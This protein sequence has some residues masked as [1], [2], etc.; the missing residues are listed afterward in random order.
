M[1]KIRAV[2][3]IFLG[4]IISTCSL[5]GVSNN[6]NNIL[7]SFDQNAYAHD[8][9]PYESASFLSFIEQLRVESELVQSNLADN[10]ISL[11][12]Q[13]ANKAAALLTPNITKEIAERVQRVSQDLSTAVSDLQNI[14]SQQQQEPSASEI[15]QL[16][17]LDAILDEAVSA[18]IDREQ[19]DNV[20][21]Q[22]LAFANLVNSV[23]RDYGNAYA[24]G[25]DMTNMSNMAGMADM[26]G[27]NRNMSL[28]SVMSTELDRNY[29]LVNAADYQSAQAL[30]NKAL[31]I[32]KT[33][34]APMES[35]SNR[36]AFIMNG[37]MQL[38]NS[39]KSKA[40]PMDIMMIVHTQIH[41]NLMKMFG[42]QLQK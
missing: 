40:S 17:N 29:S 16:A 13:H 19:R 8:F 12:H 9:T 37:L 26:P 25:F 24:V 7:P 5:N 21:I 15:N 35:S 20:T 18:R 27:S 33:K 39:I 1:R 38:N 36:T 31:E 32:F 22:A 34:L 10:N 3:L 11:A 14:S 2:V 6:Y 42:L 4:I 23:L 28:T 30:A 41:P